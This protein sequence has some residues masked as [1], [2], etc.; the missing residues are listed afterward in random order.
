MSHAATA[1]N[2]RLAT[3]GDLAALRAQGLRPAP[4]RQLVS[5]SLT[6]RPAAQFSYPTWPI[7]VMAAMTISLVV[8]R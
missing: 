2:E 7:L 1:F 5:E 3:A 6:A 8:I 4:S